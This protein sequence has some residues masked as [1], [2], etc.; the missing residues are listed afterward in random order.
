MYEI[1]AQHNWMFPLHML[2]FHTISIY[3]YG[4]TPMRKKGM[5]ACLPCTSS[6]PVHVAT[7]SLHESRFYNSWSLNSLNPAS[8]GA[9]IDCTTSIHG[10]QLFVNVPTLSFPPLRIQLQLVVSNV[11]Q[12]QTPFSQTTTAALS[13]ARPCTDTHVRNKHQCCYFSIFTFLTL[14]WN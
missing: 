3:V 14:F 13:V 11:C 10:T 8:N 9:P 7:S 5:H 12:T 4:L 1:H 2:F 6:F